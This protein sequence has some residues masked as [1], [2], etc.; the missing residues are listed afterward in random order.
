MAYADWAPD[1]YQ[2]FHDAAFEEIFNHLD[3]AYMSDDEI[4]QAEEM[5]EQGWLNMHLS[6][7]DKLA[8]REEFYNFTGLEL[9]RDQWETYREL[10]EEAGG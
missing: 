2:Y 8:A 3:F 5:F 4:A 7:E 6:S 9:D 10:Y 1:D